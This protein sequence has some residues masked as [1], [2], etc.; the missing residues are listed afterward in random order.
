MHLIR[1]SLD[2]KKDS[3][4]SDNTTTFFLN[5]KKKHSFKH[6]AFF[7]HKSSCSKEA[8][9]LGVILNDKLYW[10]KHLNY[11]FSEYGLLGL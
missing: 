9:Y 11:I 1:L 2:P 6:F 3:V 7:G 5:I 8:K 10:N 4:Y